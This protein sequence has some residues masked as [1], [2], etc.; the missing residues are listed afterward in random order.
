MGCHAEVREHAQASQAEREREDGVLQL[1][2]VSLV[3]VDPPS[4]PPDFVPERVVESG[5]LGI[6][7]RVVRER[8]LEMAEV[9]LDALPQEKQSVLVGERGEV[10]DLVDE[11]VDLGGEEGGL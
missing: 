5:P 2:S 11:L 8:S 6:D 10:L 9:L 7:E 3:M 4:E 1:L